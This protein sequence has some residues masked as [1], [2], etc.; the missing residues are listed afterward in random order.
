M[1]RLSLSLLMVIMMISVTE[2][3]LLPTQASDF[4]SGEIKLYQQEQEKRLKE[5][6]RL[7]KLK[8]V[9]LRKP[10][11]EVTITNVTL[12][13]ADQ[14]KNNIFSQIGQKLK[15]ILGSSSWLFLMIFLGAMAFIALGLRSMFRRSV[16]VA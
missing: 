8:A 14:G 16:F 12:Q 11:R 10:V 4:S 13:Q 9:Q 2:V 1:K 6:A 3:I 5:E 15:A 7:Q